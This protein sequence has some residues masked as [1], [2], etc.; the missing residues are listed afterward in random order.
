MSAISSTSL[1]KPPVCLGLSS[2]C[3]LS[4]EPANIS[5]FLVWLYLTSMF[6]SCKAYFP[7]TQTEYFLSALF[8]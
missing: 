4:N 2:N 3:F 6:P 8:L 7:L 5:L 1:P